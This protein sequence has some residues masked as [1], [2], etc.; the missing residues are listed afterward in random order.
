MTSHS[1]SLDIWP[2][3]IEDT[4]KDVVDRCAHKGS[5]DVICI[6][7][8]G[9]EQSPSRLVTWNQEY[10]DAVEKVAL[11]SEPILAAIAQQFENRIS[12]LLE[13]SH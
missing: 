13:Q 4:P 7:F 9:S 3:A 1:S 2:I 11:R 8:R 10:A 12:E 5:P 6:D